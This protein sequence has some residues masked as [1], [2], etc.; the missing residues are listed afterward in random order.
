[1][2]S[3]H[4]VTL[5]TAGGPRWWDRP[6]A[7]AARSGIGTAVVVGDAVYLVDA[8]Q[9][10]GRQLARAGL[11][12]DR[13]RA[14][15]LT[16]LHSDHVA[17]L[18]PLLLFSLF[19]RRDPA[20]APIEV[21]GPGPRGGLPPL[22]PH[23]T[24]HPEPVAPANPAPGTAEMIDLLCA[25]H[26]TDLN[27]RIFD[28]LTCR[29]ADHLAVHDIALPPGTGFDPDARVAPPMEPFEVH[30]DDVV[31]VTAI[32]VEHPPTAPAFAFRF[33][34]AEGSVT[35]SGDTAPCANLVRLA[36]DTDLLLHEAI[37]LSAMGRRYADEARRQ[38]TMAHHRRAHT[39]ARQ[40]GE[41]ATEAG[42]RALALHHLV[43]GDAP[44]TAFSA[45]AAETFHGPV[46]VPDDLDV[47]AFASRTARGRTEVA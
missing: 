9:G 34:A 30:R 45:A 1:M 35:I 7:A 42:A 27:D 46:L 32:L 31:V 44:A 14:L 18:V 22:S 25:A 37:D 3:P 4:V 13:V 21:H 28:S 10:T 12:L 16:H 24:E 33:D 5:G 40:A 8:G 20:A 29:P 41:L 6:G 23:A 11:P 43:P 2:S 26:A 38:A 39:T 36:R 15:F 17:D 47:I 19:E